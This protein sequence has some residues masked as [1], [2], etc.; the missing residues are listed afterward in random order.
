MSIEDRPLRLNSSEEEHKS[1]IIRYYEKA[2]LFYR[3]AWHRGTNGLHYGLWEKG[4]KN[5]FEAIINE[6]RVLADM[7]AIKPGD[8]VLDAGCGIGGSGIWLAKNRGAKVVGLNIVQ[9]QIEEGRKIARKKGLSDLVTFE[10]GDYQQMPFPDQSFDVVW[11]LESLEHASDPDEFIKEAFRML[12]PGGRLI[13]VATFLGRTDLTPQEISQMKVGQ[14]V[15][16]C[17][18][19]FRTAANIAKVMQQ[20]GFTA[21]ANSDLTNEVMPS[22]ARMRMMCRVTYPLAVSAGKLRIVP[23][24]MVKNSLWGMYQEGL[25]NSGAT[26]YNILLAT[27]PAS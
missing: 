11:S 23:D 10:E 14:E 16:G 12:K 26:S 6:N 18:N 25:F 27:K 1:R 3:L 9:K 13:I 2:H 21:V 7:I 17:F 22:A 24:F 5:R 19:D 4:M 15:S 20:A 8:R